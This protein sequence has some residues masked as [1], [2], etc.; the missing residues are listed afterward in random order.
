MQASNERNA[1]QNETCEFWKE[2]IQTTDTRRF[3]FFAMVKIFC[4]NKEQVW[5]QYKYKN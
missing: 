3:I 1:D 5:V 2:L 4:I